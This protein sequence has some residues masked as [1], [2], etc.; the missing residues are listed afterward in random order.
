MF[1][2]KQD[3]LSLKKKIFALIKKIPFLLKKTPSLIKKMPYTIK[4]TYYSVRESFFFM[5][6]LIFFK[7]GRSYLMK[8]IRSSIKA[9][10]IIFYLAILFLILP[11]LGLGLYISLDNIIYNSVDTGLLSG[12]GALATLISNENNKIELMFSDEIMSEYNSVKSKNFFEIR[13]F[14]GSVIEKSRS[15]KNRELPFFST[16]KKISYHTFDINDRTVRLVNFRFMAGENKNDLKDRKD[17]SKKENGKETPVIRQGKGT[18]VIIQCALD[19]DDLD[20]IMDT[21]QSSAFISILSILLISAA[22]GFLIAKKAL[23]PIKEISETIKNISESNLSERIDHENVPKELQELAVSF[24][25]TIK[26]L[27][28]SFK[29]QKQLTGDASH[30]LRTPLSVILSQSEITLRKDRSGNEYK[31]SLMSI[32]DAAE[33]MSAIVEKLLALARLGNE[34]IKLQMKP[35]KLNNIISQAIKTVTPFAEFKDV[36]INLQVPAYITP[37]IFGNRPSLLELFINILENAVKYNVPEGKIDIEIDKITIDEKGGFFITKIKD[38]GIGINSHDIDKVFDR[39]Y[40]ADTSRSKKVEGIGLG[41][42]ICKEIVRLHE[43]TIEIKST[44]GIGTIVSIR[45]AAYLHKSSDENEN[46]VL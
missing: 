37:V 30:E 28:E 27:E 11:F 29:R 36:N 20:D 7:N 10:I 42:S 40:R 23:S 44:Q 4:I 21:F 26:R 34:E 32:K 14:D 18:G 9:R 19:T 15:L 33:M 39:F 35:V 8:T 24:N 1:F 5:T 41:L 12:A 38:T 22:G 16:K 43:G 6:T 3:M 31:T 45:F 2:S 25:R 46:Q 17:G 13:R